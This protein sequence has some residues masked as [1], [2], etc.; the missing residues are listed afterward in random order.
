MNVAEVFEKCVLSHFFCRENRWLSATYT[1]GLW[2]DI[3]ALESELHLVRTA[4][5][6]QSGLF[7]HI[8]VARESNKACFE[9][10]VQEYPE[11]SVH[12]CGTS[13]HPRGTVGNN[14]RSF[15]LQT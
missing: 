8:V 2:G 13:L 1:Q 4:G 6:Q 9:C 11:V 3:P 14:F 15:I 12:V 5:W 10:Q 7:E